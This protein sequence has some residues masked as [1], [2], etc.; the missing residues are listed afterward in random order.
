MYPEVSNVT[1]TWDT[2]YDRGVGSEYA[3]PA[4]SVV[5]CDIGSVFYLLAMIATASCMHFYMRISK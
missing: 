2:V 1:N 5:L 3:I 4:H